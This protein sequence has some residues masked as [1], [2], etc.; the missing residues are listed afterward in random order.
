MENPALKLHSILRETYDNTNAFDSYASSWARIF[1]IDRD[2]PLALM[3]NI[4]GL[5]NLFNETLNLV[6]QNERLNT[7]KNKRFLLK[8]Q[9]AIFDIN[10]DGNMH[11]FTDSIDEETLTALYFIGELIYYQYDLNE[12][13]VD[14]EKVDEILNEVNDL[15]HSI[16]ESP[17]PKDVQDILINN[18]IL[19]KDALD[20]Y[21]FW[22]EEVLRKALEQTIG[23]IAINKSIID[24]NQ[25]DNIYP[26]FG[27]VLGKTSSLITIGTAIKDYLLP[28][29]DKLPFK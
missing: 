20:R 17:L 27:D 7:E 3:R 12:S 21:K 23:S 16:A 8:I 22:G 13:K 29:F 28:L 25:D 5:L 2:D 14:N 19:I 15:I 18:L 26:R 11:K 6:E 4:S 24:E 9:D 10:F 1:K